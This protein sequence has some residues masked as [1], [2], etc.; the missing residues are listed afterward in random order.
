VQRFRQLEVEL[1][2]GVP[3]EVLD[4]VSDAL[5]DE[6]A[7][8]AMAAENDVLA[9]GPRAAEPPFAVPAIDAGAQAGDLFRVA[10]AAT[11]ERLIRTDALL[12]RPDGDD[13]EPLH[14]ARVAVRRLRSH[15]RAFEPILDRAWA[16]DLSER[17]RWWG[18]AL[19]DARDAD[20]LDVQL[21][22]R[23]DA[24]PAADRPQ[25]DGVL[26][27]FRARRDEAY[28]TVANDLRDP[29]YIPLLDAV[30]EAAERP[31]FAGRAFDPAYDV[32][33][34]LLASS[35]RK[36]RKAVRRRSRPPQDPELHRI[37]IRAKRV[38]YV[39][40]A[41]APAFGARAERF[42]RCVAALQT[43]LG[44]QHDAVVAYQQLREA[45][46]AGAAAFAAGEL[47]ALAVIAADEGRQGWRAP[48]RAA[49]R[50]RFW[51]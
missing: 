35:W 48:W 46:G 41:V 23:A 31:V 30:V 34:E 28:R 4:T 25:I 17:L 32:A 24:L 14:Q 26:A 7:T 19:G 12:R 45:A 18:D 21:R 5:R 36:L 44:E 51:R 10:F 47:A 11:A 16:G 38:R 49:R 20:V 33:P 43:V 42:A 29:R 8:P 9:L 1:A 3:A 2:E 37:R 40:E 27:R 6:G 39:A 15:L 50:Q 13:P 22:A